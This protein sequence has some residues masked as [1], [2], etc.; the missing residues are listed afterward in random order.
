MKSLVLIFA[1]FAHLAV[2]RSPSPVAPPLPSEG[3]AVVPELAR[4][5]ESPIEA[6]VETA[7][8]LRESPKAPEGNLPEPILKTRPATSRDAR[9]SSLGTVMVGYQLITSWLPSKKSLGYTHI[10]SDRWSL[11][12]EYS[13]QTIDTP[14][15]G[16]DLGEIRER[17]FTLH[18]RRY[19]GNSFHFTS[20]AVYS[21]FKAGLGSDFLDDLGNE[22]NSEFSAD[23]LGVTAGLGNR[24]QWDNGITLGVDWLRLNVPVLETRVED[25][26]LDDVPG[27]RDREDVKDVIRTFNRIPTFVILGLN[28]GY[29]F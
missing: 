24:W 23:N 16:V 17:R 10:F 26:V 4:P 6:V 14:F 11:E 25:N 19:V 5:A 1:F 7:A 15:I 27:A 21:A 13:F 28:L 20:G 29:T 8:P 22:L 12:G 3:S 18:A 9:A 2:A